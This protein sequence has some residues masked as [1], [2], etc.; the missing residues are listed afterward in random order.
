MVTI[1]RDSTSVILVKR[2][3]SGATTQRT[4]IK[5]SGMKLRERNVQ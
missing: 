3:E 1:S 4:T 5:K 2:L